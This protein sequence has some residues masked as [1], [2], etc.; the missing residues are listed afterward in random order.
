MYRITCYYL[1]VLLF[2]LGL[3]GCD[4]PLAATT[5]TL[6]PPTQLSTTLLPFT[7]TLLPTNAA[8]Q[9]TELVPTLISPPSP[10]LTLLPTQTANPTR[11]AML[12]YEHYVKYLQQLLLDN[13]GE[14]SSPCFWGIIPGQ[15]TLGEAQNFFA[16]LGRPLLQT[17][18]RGDKVF[19]GSIV[20]FGNGLAVSVVLKV[21]NELISEV[22]AGIGLGNDRGPSL[23]REWLAYSPE[24]L[25]LQYGVPSR[26]MVGLANY[27][28]DPAS[29]DPGKLYYLTMFFDSANLI[30]EYYQKRGTS[31]P[32]HVCP[33][34]DNFDGVELWFGV[35]PEHP[36]SGGVSLEEATFLTIE[37]FYDLLTDTAGTPCFY[38]KLDSMS[39]D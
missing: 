19:Y 11:P 27:P 13:G 17:N 3:S 1:L 37:Q 21:Q 25:L 29:S 15:T 39:P 31:N 8:P 32:Y 5:A 18:T 34:T 26:V 6:S 23:P 10:A 24:T 22:R 2:L 33:L 9:T 38:L 36:P 30:V 7:P 20:G 16:Y 28:T 35:S 4:S 14:C 12:D